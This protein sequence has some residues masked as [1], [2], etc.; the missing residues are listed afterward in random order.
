MNEEWVIR[1]I[2]F[3]SAT[4]SVFRFQN[5]I[6]GVVA[7]IPSGR[8]NLETSWDQFKVWRI[9][10]EFCNLHFLTCFDIIS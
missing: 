8:R 3:L 5:S 10:F 6:A 7:F 2:A 9:R 4:L 1:R